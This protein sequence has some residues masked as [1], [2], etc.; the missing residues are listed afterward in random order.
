M[1]PILFSNPLSAANSLNVH[2]GAL[3]LRAGIGLMMAFGHGW[4]KFTNFAEIAPGFPDPLGLGTGLSLGLAVFAEWFCSILITLGFMTRLAT[5][6]L[7]VTMLV[8]I[9][10]VHSG[11][12]FAQKE[13][14][15]LYLFS[16]LVL[17]G[18]GAG[19]ASLDQFFADRY[20][21]DASERA[22]S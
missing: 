18:M 3:L 6:P 14:A 22:D 13:K 5:V 1:L 7:I 21:H 17:A 10:S 11:D 16:Y 8:A 19:K 12:P 20:I 9:L 4:P 15:L 2:F